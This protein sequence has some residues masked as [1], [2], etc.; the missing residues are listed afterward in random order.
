[1]ASRS[2]SARSC[3]ASGTVILFKAHDVG[4]P[5]LVIGV[6]GAAGDARLDCAAVEAAAIITAAAVAP[7]PPLPVP[8]LPA[9]EP[10]FCLQTLMHAQSSHRQIVHYFG[11]RRR[12]RSL[13]A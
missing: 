7:P 1:M 2:Q 13:Q 3:W 5:A 4:A 10:A 8:P 6:T 12:H 11:A 9:R